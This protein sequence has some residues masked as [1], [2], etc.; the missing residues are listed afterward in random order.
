[1]RKHGFIMLLV[2]LLSFSVIVAAGN[3]DEFTI[4]QENILNQD[5]VEIQTVS[6]QDFG[7]VAVLS[8]CLSEQVY[9]DYFYNE[10]IP[11]DIGLEMDNIVTP[12]NNLGFAQL[13][14]IDESRG[15]YLH[16]ASH[17]QQISFFS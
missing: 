15:G 11:A 17:Y 12:Y 8:V 2:L 3:F 7:G 10:T 9:E 14:I 1:M 4:S 16:F 5:V 6:V 13:T